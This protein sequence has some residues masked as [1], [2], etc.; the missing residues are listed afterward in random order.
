MNLK[1]NDKRK[2]RISKKNLTGNK[3]ILFLGLRTKYELGEQ[4]LGT[5]VYKVISINKNK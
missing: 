4:D 5:K 1:Y 3:K 2:K